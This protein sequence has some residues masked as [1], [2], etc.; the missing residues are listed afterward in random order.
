MR[1][2]PSLLICFAAAASAA[3]IDFTFKGIT[4]QASYNGAPLASIDLS[5]DLRADTANLQTG[6]GWQGVGLL[7]QLE[8]IRL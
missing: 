3:T 7:S 4:A 8:G 5:V 6:R 2:F 1:L